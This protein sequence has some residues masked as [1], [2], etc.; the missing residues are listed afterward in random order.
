[1]KRW[2]ASIV[3]LLI[4]VSHISA[5]G[6]DDG[7]ASSTER[8]FN[9]T[10]YP[11]VDESITLDMVT[12]RANSKSM[13]FFIEQEKVTNIDVNWIEIPSADMVT[14]TNLMFASNDL[15]DAFYTAGYFITDSDLLSY[16]GKAI[17]PL[18]PLFEYAP[19]LV[20]VFGQRPQYKAV[21]TFPDGHIYALPQINERAI[22]S[23]T[24]LVINADWLEK[25]GMDVPETTDEFYEVLKAFK[26]AGDINGNGDADEWPFSYGGYRLFGMFGSFG[27]PDNGSHMWVDGKKVI[28]TAVREEY[29]KAIQYFHKLFAEGLIY[30]ESYTADSAIYMANLKALPPNFGG[31]NT[32]TL[33]ARFG[34]GKTH[35]YQYMRPL[36]GPDGDRYWIRD[37]WEI[38]GKNGFLITV[39]N[40]HPEATMR[41]IDRIIEPLKSFESFWGTVGHNWK[42]EA[43]GSLTEI[44][45]PE[46]LAWGSWIEQVSPYSQGYQII[47]SDFYQNIALPSADAEKA[48]I[49]SD[50]YTDYL[51]PDLLPFPKVTLTL[52]EQKRLK[53]LSTDISSFVN[54]NYTRW[55]MNGG[56]EGDWDKYLEKL[57]D[58]GF[59]E[60]IVIHQGA[61]ERYL[62]N[63]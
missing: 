14:K 32:W 55:I 54:E 36:K 25:V 33:S 18:D 63:L 59:Q 50:Y 61:Y 44:P 23:N 43:D 3:A 49:C 51:H 21:M 34:L 7:N 48:Q 10:G 38:H 37:P 35:G 60:F 15:P 53:L 56:I 29:K 45:A 5:A 46:G 41:W 40:K 24:S 19:N 57:D 8:N 30:P 6:Q 58:M 16:A 20:K 2:F 39:K 11:I 42:K 13:E 26:K 52:E 4:L 9:K 62:S 47:L 12:V 22:T 1:M 27:L 17:I 31:F 28:Y